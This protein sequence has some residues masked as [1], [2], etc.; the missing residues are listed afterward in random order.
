M[1]YPPRLLPSGWKLMV[2]IHPELQISF[3]LSDFPGATNLLSLSLF[4]RCFIS[5]KTHFEDEVSI[6]QCFLSKPFANGV[7][8]RW[9]WMKDVIFE[10]I[11]YETWRTACALLEEEKARTRALTCPALLPSGKQKP[12]QTNKQNK[13]T[14][15]PPNPFISCEAE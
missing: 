6:W 13:L 11:D 15:K 12:K 9:G 5:A 2:E 14:R 8:A 4:Y 1:L 3:I 10:L 7:I